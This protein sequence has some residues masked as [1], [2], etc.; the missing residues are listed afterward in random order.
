DTLEMLRS[1]F[2][3]FKIFENRIPKGSMFSRDR[4]LRAARGEIVLS[5]DDDSYPIERDFFQRLRV[6]FLQHPEAAAVVFPELRDDNVFSAA[7]KTDKSPGHYVAA[8]ANCAAAMRREFYLKH[9][10]FPVFFTHMYEE[11]DFAVRC[12]AQGAA[13]WFEPRLTVRHHQ[14]PV[15]RRPIARHHFN[16]RNELWSVWMRCPWPWVTVVSAYRVLRQ[17]LY[18]RSEGLAWLLREP[19]WWLAAL[20]GLQQCR[21]SRQPVAWRAYYR[22]MRLARN[23]IYEVQKLREKFPQAVSTC[24]TPDACLVR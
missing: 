12:Y 7:D 8:Y 13:V 24:A 11:A 20:K 15:N 1:R 14:S 21:H 17:L 3:R 18:A 19:V 22:W 2:P 4:I 5:L 16:A 6:I 9:E 10:G 23:P